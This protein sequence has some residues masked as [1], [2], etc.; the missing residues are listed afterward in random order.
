MAL[1]FRTEQLPTGA[2]AQ[3]ISEA[4]RNVRAA[5]VRDHVKKIGVEVHYPEAN[6]PGITNHGYRYEIGD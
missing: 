3:A 1:L 5:L 2:N 6:N 4:L